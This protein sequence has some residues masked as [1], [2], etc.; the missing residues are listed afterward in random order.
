MKIAFLSFCILLFSCNEK[1]DTS[2]YPPVITL[3]HPLPIN[4]SKKRY[5]FCNYSWK[6]ENGEEYL[7]DVTLRTDSGFFRERDVINYVVGN[8]RIDTMQ[9]KVIIYG[10]FEF[11]NESDYNDFNKKDSVKPKSK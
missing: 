3:S 1:K 7:G 8:Y 2:Y 6:S 4:I 5:F 11:K 10:L 9:H